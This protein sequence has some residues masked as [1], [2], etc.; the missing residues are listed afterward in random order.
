[1]GVTK[2]NRPA[3][4]EAG[5]EDSAH[6]SY[7]GERS[8]DMSTR[9]LPT[10]K[11]GMHTYSVFGAP[12][13]P[14]C[15]AWIPDGRYSCPECGIRRY[16]VGH[17]VD[18]GADFSYCDSKCMAL[19]KDSVIDHECNGV[20]D[21]ALP[22]CLSHIELPE[23]FRWVEMC[24]QLADVTEYAND[25]IAAQEH[26]I[27]GVWVVCPNGGQHLLAHDSFHFN[28]GK[29]PLVEWIAE[30]IANSTANPGARQHS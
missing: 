1:M 21:P 26:H 8:N 27:E 11:R 25:A 14:D 23:G 20:H 15:C 30:Q 9:V 6:G 28:S 7:V 16:W 22:S 10:T 3:S 12:N 18:T 17:D 29:M 2:R 5:D 19:T 24:D 4:L 13:C